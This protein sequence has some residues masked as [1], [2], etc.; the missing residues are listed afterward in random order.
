[1]N[2]R[3]NFCNIFTIKFKNQSITDGQLD[4]NSKKEVLV[5]SINA[6][7]SKMTNINM[8][9]NLSLSKPKDIQT[10]NSICITCY[11]SKNIRTGSSK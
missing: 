5:W 3:P 4:V 11:K 10:S 2:T 6:E 9:S 1:M 8:P 7:I